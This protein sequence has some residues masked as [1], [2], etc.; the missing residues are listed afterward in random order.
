MINL[1]SV[2]LQMNTP[3]HTMDG[4]GGGFGLGMMILF[5]LLLLALIVT[6]IWFLIRKGSDSTLKPEDETALETLKKRYARG[7][8]SEEEFRRIRKEI[9][10]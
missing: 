4:W 6:L 7:E 2:F 8:I 5:W 10:E 1:N 3:Q 9:S